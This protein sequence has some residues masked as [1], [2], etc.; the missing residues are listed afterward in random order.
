MSKV[1]EIIAAGAESPTTCR[2]YSTLEFSQL[3][4]SCFAQRDLVR[5]SPVA[6]KW[7]CSASEQRTPSCRSYSSSRRNSAPPSPPLAPTLRYTPS[8]V[9]ASSCRPPVPPVAPEQE[10]VKT[11]LGA[12]LLL[13]LCK[14]PELVRKS[15]LFGL[16]CLWRQE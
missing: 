13:V 10:R 2:S 3:T 15:S 8:A 1:N 7:R 12:V 6:K 4:H 5:S 11:T 16:I 9:F 14:M